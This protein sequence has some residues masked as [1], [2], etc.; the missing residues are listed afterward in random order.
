VEHELASNRIRRRAQLAREHLSDL[1]EQVFT[2]LAQIPISGECAIEIVEVVTPGNVRPTVRFR[3][4]DR[5]GI[6]GGMGFSIRAHVLPDFI[7]AAA[8]AMDLLA[9]RAAAAA[10]RSA[11]GKADLR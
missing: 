3:V 9:E 2:R 6:V 4:R 5:N 8:D 1:P 7:D 10:A 11:F